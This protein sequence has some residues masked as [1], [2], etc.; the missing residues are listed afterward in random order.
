VFVLRTA[1]VVGEQPR[2]EDV[3]REGFV[4]LDVKRLHAGQYPS[5]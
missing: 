1:G 2:V 5:L 4:V 3:L